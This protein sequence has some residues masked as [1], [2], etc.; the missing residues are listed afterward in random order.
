MSTSPA[1]MHDW[2]EERESAR[3]IE[4]ADAIADRIRDLEQSSGHGEDQ[5]NLIERVLERVFESETVSV[6]FNRYM[7]EIW[8]FRSSTTVRERSARN[9]AT[10]IIANLIA[11]IVRDIVSS[12]VR[13]EFD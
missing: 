6:A 1:N 8:K 3:D 10:Q 11:P 2:K 7:F 5:Q 4:I 9:R 13:K 12:D